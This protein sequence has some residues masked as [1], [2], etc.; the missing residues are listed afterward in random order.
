MSETQPI[1][2]ANFVS[3]KLVDEVRKETGDKSVHRIVTDLET[4]NKYNYILD[5]PEVSG[6][7]VT[8]PNTGNNYTIGK[9][10]ESANNNQFS[11]VQEL[12]KL[13]ENG[14]VIQ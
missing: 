8:N 14:N 5:R 9:R 6:V 7:K 10:L 2:Q 11:K 1:D 12:P 4:Q 3:G 13:D